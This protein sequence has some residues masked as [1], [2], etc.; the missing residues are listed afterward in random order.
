VIEKLQ[1]SAV[2][3]ADGNTMLRWHRL[4][5]AAVECFALSLS[6][7]KQKQ[8]ECKPKPHALNRRYQQGAA[9]EHSLQEGVH[10]YSSAAV[11]LIAF[12]AKP[13]WIRL[14][15]QLAVVLPF[16][17]LPGGAQAVD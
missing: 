10:L 17:D 11:A 3:V 4:H 15:R 14:Q 1:C 12:T 5:F 7:F 9:V 16:D 8:R 2:I 6:A 13:A